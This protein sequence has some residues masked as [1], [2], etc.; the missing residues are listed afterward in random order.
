[1]Q[2]RMIMVGASMALAA[3]SDAGAA[4]TA[5]PTSILPKLT[6]KDLGCN[7]KATAAAPKIGD[8]VPLARIYGVANGVKVKEDKRSGE[9]H[10]A[11]KGTFRGKVVQEGVETNG[12]I[13]SSGL[14]YLPG[15][16]HEL[17]EAPLMEAE[18]AGNVGEVKF[19]LDIW[20]VRNGNAA[21]FSYGATIVGE[22]MQN[23]PLAEME[24]M[25]GIT[26]A[27]AAPALEAP[28]E[29]PAPVEAPAAEEAAKEP[30]KK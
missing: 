4:A 21:G 8:R 28:A 30:A 16:I 10:S 13:F 12:Q 19:A 2:H 18:A 5:A 20:A 3:A 24:A 25:L 29:T 15:G 27:P 7:A 1:M 11:L 14:L 23:D 17:I 22:P 26:A 9:F 6:I